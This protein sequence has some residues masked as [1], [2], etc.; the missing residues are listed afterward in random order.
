MYQVI[1][2]IDNRKS[3]T[4][5]GFKQIF[6][7]TLTGYQLQFAVILVSRRSSDLIGRHHRDVVLQEVL[8]QRC[9][10]RTGRTIHKY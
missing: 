1:D 10:V 4:D 6:H 2:G 5:V 9:N 8:I 7:T 3:G